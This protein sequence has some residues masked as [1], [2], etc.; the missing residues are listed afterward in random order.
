M[1]RVK[2]V[3]E[4]Y[5]GGNPI[6]MGLDWGTGENTYTVM[7]LAGYLP[8]FQDRFTFFYFKRFE[9]SESEP[10]VQ[11]DYITKMAEFFNVAYI[12]VDYGGGHWPNDILIRRFGAEKVKIY[13]W[14]GRVKKKISYQTGLGVPRYLCH[15]TEVMSDFFNAVKR[16]DVFT[17]PRWEEFQDP[18]GSDF[19]NIFSEYSDR[20]H[21]NV[22]KHALGCP[23]DSAHSSIYNFMGSMHY[24]ARPDV[25][26]PRR[27]EA[28]QET[29]E[30]EE[31][32]IT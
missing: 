2:E 14:V 22:Y 31:L 6:F 27:E 24:R 20:L 3:G 5:G 1:K 21:M 11:I 29:E 15:R 23:D 25:I 16:R 8:I 7:S 12:G 10:K 19:L 30:N 4:R 32:D 26:L 9:G 13:Q 17:F 28:V 18:F